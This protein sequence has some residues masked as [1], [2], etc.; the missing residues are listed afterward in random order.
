M[1]RENGSS[2]CIRFDLKTQLLQFVYRKFMSCEAIALHSGR[3][4]YLLVCYFV[5]HNPTIFS[6]CVVTDWTE[7]YVSLVDGVFFETR[8]FSGAY[9][10]KKRTFLQIDLQAKSLKPSRAHLG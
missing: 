2:I 6:F 7:Q 4:W 9:K 1:F 10:V 3:P 5:T 8:V